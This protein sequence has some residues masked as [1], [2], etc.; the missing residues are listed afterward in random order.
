[1]ICNTTN[2]NTTSS[3]FVA[4]GLSITLTPVSS[5]SKFYI[6]YSH[7]PHQN[8]SGYNY[9]GQHYLYRDSTQTLIGGGYRQDAGSGWMTN[10]TTTT[11]VDSPATAS[12]ITYT[13]KMN[14]GMRSRDTSAAYINRPTTFVQN[15]AMS[16]RAISTATIMEIKG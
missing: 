1:M 9:W 6:S 10:S 2:L 14:S 11:G 5:S 12:A 4:T 16:P 8:T 13:V 7:A 3:S 15:D